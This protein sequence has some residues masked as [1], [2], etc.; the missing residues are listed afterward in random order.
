MAIQAASALSESESPGEVG[1]LVTVALATMLAPLNSTMIAVALPQVIREFGV[2]VAAAGWLVT[3]YLIAMAS[4][5]PVAGKLGD[6]WGR[7][8]LIL[9][10]VASFGLASIGA[11]L[12]S[13]PASLLFFRVLQAVSGAVALP[14]GAALLREVVPAERQAGR[15]GMVG[16]AIA[17][18]AAAGPARGG[19]PGGSAGGTPP[20]EVNPLPYRPHAAE[21]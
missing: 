6:R 7:R 18:A 17:L 9:G 11:A 12:A 1:V 16:A 14:N 20:F 5:Q 19:I 8:Q 21:R 2:D 13:S 4:L 10:G 15:F 3:A